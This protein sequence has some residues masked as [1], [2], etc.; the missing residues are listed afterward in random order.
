MLLGAFI[1]LCFVFWMG[2]RTLKRS[3]RAKSDGNEDAFYPES[4]TKTLLSRI[5]YLGRTHR[6]WRDLDDST[7]IHGQPSMFE[8]S[9]SSMLG[10]QTTVYATKA[11][12][13]ASNM[14]SSLFRRGPGPLPQLDTNVSFA[15]VN[16]YSSASTMDSA[17]TAAG[18]GTQNQAVTTYIQQPAIALS[19]PSRSNPSPAVV[20][21]NPFA[22]PEDDAYP[23]NEI[24]SPSSAL[25]Y[26]NG[27][28][29]TFA[30]TATD[31][32]R[33]PDPYFNQS[34]LARQAS[35]AFD[36]T[37]RVVYR[38][39]ELSSLSSGFGDGDI[40]VPMPAASSYAPSI[41]ATTSNRDTIY[42]TT[43]EDVPAR[44]RS[45]NSWV[46]QQTGRVQRAQTRADEEDVPPV[47]SLP[48]EERL[49]LMMDDGEEPR[50]YEDTLPPPVPQ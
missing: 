16:P 36:P 31:R 50:R 8:Q 41:A 48:A 1:L 3:K 19:P 43:S 20:I 30:T 10:T 46:N 7:S 18:P 26:G 38:A 42:T 11:S 2:W 28:N 14:A 29:E 5:P 25:Q 47:P 32:S 44:Y 34:E 37:K 12:N 23:T 17:F 15:P 13:M 45:V 39:S 40:I 21:S 24:A 27:T 4:K 22:S 49:T 35:T 33:M 6:Q 9:K